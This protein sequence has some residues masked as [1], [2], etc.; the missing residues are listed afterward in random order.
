MRAWTLLCYEMQ[1]QLDTTHLINTNSSPYTRGVQGYWLPEVT[2]R[3]E[4]LLRRI[5]ETAELWATG[6]PGLTL[7]VPGGGAGWLRRI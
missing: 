3:R 5:Y 7:N 4:A 1:S 2:S 6:V